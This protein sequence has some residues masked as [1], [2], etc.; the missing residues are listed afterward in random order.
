MQKIDSKKIRILSSFIFFLVTLF[1]SYS[2]GEIFYNSIDGTDFYRYFKYIEYFRGDID[3]PSREQGV[4]YFWIIAI[5]VESS[6]NFFLPDKWEYIY[7]TAIQLGNFILYLIGIIGFMLLMRLKKIDWE[8]I[9]LTLSVLN[10]LPPVIGGRLIMKPEIL[11]FALLPWVI[12]SLFNYFDNK[13]SYSETVEKIK[14]NS[15]NYAKRQITWLKK[16]K[17]SIKIN[18]DDDTNYIFKKLNNIL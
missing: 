18:Y 14:Q 5:L 1:T 9:F 11:G 8:D 16:Y 15:R 17:N 12:L 2:L 13:I 3:S 4:F 6:Q 10:F 7:S